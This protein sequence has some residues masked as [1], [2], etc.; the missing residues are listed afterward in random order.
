M[1]LWAIVPVKPLRR[2]KSR[3]SGVLSEDDRAELNRRLLVHTVSTLKQIPEI[4]DVLVVSRD[5]EALAIARE[6]GARTLQ[7]DGAPHLNVALERAALVAQS[8]HANRLLVLPADLPQL[9]A[10]GVQAL[11]AEGQQPPVVVLAPDHRQEGTNALY[12]NPAGAIAFDFGE[13]SFERHRQRAL[14]AGVDLRVLEHA[15]LAHDVD[16]PDD[17]EFLAAPLNELID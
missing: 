9:S 5:T 8:Y 2:G 12:M 4:L 1:T 15:T 16:V 14:A 13:G 17:L 3:L 7:E 6:H 10:E 11:L